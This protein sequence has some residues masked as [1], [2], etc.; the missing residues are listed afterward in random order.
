MSVDLHVHVP[1]KVKPAA[2]KKAT[3]D[4][5]ALMGGELAAS[6]GGVVYPP[7]T[8]TAKA[9]RVRKKKRKAK[10]AGTFEESKH[11]RG[12]GG[13]FGHGAMHGYHNA[14]Q[15]FHEN[16]HK[17]LSAHNPARAGLYKQA[18]EL[19]AHAAAAHQDAHEGYP[20]AVEKDRGDKL[21]QSA[22]SATSRAH[23]FEH[24][25]KLERHGEA[26][27][28]EGGALSKE[29]HHAEMHQHLKTAQSL[30]DAGNMDGA[31]QY[32]KHAEKSA[33]AAKA[34]DNAPGVA[35]PRAWPMTMRCT[36]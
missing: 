23:V 25:H 6:G 2:V 28:H 18:A 8:S 13:K 3:K 20:A 30:I 5:G 26:E 24:Q 27:E 31:Q 33:L 35:T 10:D 36:S 9:W 14:A 17:V 12:Q 19:H 11:P 7:L 15:K 32:I 22:R 29:Q 4:D 21:R 1:V 34:Y 16:Q